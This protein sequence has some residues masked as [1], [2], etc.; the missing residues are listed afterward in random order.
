MLT[1]MKMNRTLIVDTIS[2]RKC[3]Q[4]KDNS[5]L[6]TAV[7]EENKCVAKKL[8]KYRNNLQKQFAPQYYKKDE[9]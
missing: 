9:F 7:F 1:N 8:Q 3:V 4:P 6:K 5:T 2:V